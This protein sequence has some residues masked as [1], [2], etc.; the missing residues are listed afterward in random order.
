MK[1]QDRIVITGAGIICSLGQHIQNIWED[2]LQGKA[3]S[4]PIPEEWSTYSDF[5]SQFWA[6]LPKRD[7]SY[8][9]LGRS[10]KLRMDEVTMLSIGASYQALETAN[11]SFSPRDD[12][13]NRFIIEDYAPHRFGIYF[14]T[15]TGGINT[16]LSAH[17]T[18]LLKQKAIENDYN[19]PFEQRYNPLT[20]AMLMPN[21]AAAATGIRFGAEGPNRTISLA[22]ASGTAAIGEAF[23]AIKRGDIDVALS[24]GMEF[25]SDPYGSIFRSYDITG[26]LTRGFNQ[27][28]ACNR[29]FDQ[30]RNGFL[31][32][33][34]GA[35][36]LVL[37][38]ESHAK[39]RNA[40][41]WAEL[42]GFEETFDCHNLM[43]IEPRGQQIK[44][45]IQKS[46]SNCGFTN[47]DFTYINTHGTGTTINDEVELNIIEN[48]FGQ[49]PLINSTKGFI[50][51]TIGASGA[52][53]A[54]ITALS[55]RDGL[56]HPCNNL[57]NPIRDLNF[58]LQS[59]K[60]PIGPAISQSF[61]FGGH[62]CCL[63]LNDY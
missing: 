9:G 47:N 46:I 18:H 62:N 43:T 13:A 55:F 28:D 29:P 4:Q 44:T 53:E 12:K 45:M 19:I 27:A 58:P 59:I 22:C 49:K 63:I 31:F 16:T 39:A 33:E 7:Y 35:G 15:G 56:V 6:P 61:A 21:A 5:K 52:I 11:L 17:T 36:V 26:A 32:G 48:I 51:H 40:N 41:I 25:L 50:G 24:G 57:V 8:C 37:E 14:G 34:G 30:H 2:V 10:D 20:V 42:C 1:N 23:Q 3:I 54:A 60:K 38:R